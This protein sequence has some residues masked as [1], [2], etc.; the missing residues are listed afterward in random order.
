[1]PEL[2]GAIFLAAL[3]LVAVPASMVLGLVFVSRYVLP[4]TVGLVVAVSLLCREKW[5]VCAVLLLFTARQVW[6]ARTLFDR[7]VPSE[8]A[9]IAA[10]CRSVGAPIVL[11]SYRAFFQDLYYGPPD[12]RNCVVYLTDKPAAVRHIGR[13][14]VEWS[15]QQL[16][17]RAPLPVY[18]YSDFVRTHKRFYVWDS[19]A[20]EFPVWLPAQLRQ[21]GAR[22][23]GRTPLLEVTF[24]DEGSADE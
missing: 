3:P 22:I 20:E 6:H 11:S 18:D 16:H 5:I 21:D 9:Q 14:S 19:L 24:S 12:I 17:R 15:V 23:E 2:A 4:V 13:S 1:M 8:A 10:A 7:P